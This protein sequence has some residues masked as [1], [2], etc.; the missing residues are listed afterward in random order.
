MQKYNHFLKESSMF[1]DVKIFIEQLKNIYGNQISIN[2]EKNPIKVIVKVVDKPVLSIYYDVDN[3]V[4]VIEPINKEK[5]E[6]FKWFDIDNII[7][8]CKTYIDDELRQ[9]QVQV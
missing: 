7:D 5:T 9:I 1:A 4:V 2:I 3:D 8:M 6:Y